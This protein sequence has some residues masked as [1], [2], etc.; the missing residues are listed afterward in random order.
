MNNKTINFNCG[1]LI[2]LIE[3]TINFLE[4]LG[5]LNAL[6]VL[7]KAE[8]S[9]K[10]QNRNVPNNTTNNNTISLYSTTLG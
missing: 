1:Q 8:T 9:T 4:A 6:S 2:Q 5:V 3:K 10:K 7:F